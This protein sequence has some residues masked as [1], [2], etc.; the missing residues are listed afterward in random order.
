VLQDYT[1]AIKWYSKAAA[2][3]HALAEANLGLLYEMGWGVPQDYSQ[4][5]ELE[6]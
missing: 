6:F 1:E 5:N 2:H 3:G 4:A